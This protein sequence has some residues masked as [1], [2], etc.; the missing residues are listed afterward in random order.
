VNTELGRRWKDAV[1]QSF[2]LLQKFPGMTE[3][4]LEDLIPI[5]RFPGLH[6]NAKTTVY[7]VGGL[8]AQPLC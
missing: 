4:N 8:T 2:I 3:G 6:L 1:V 7:G 5:S